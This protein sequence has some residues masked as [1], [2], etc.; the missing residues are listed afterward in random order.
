MLLKFSLIL[1]LLYSCNNSEKKKIIFP[2]KAPSVGTENLQKSANGL[3]IFSPAEGSLVSLP[4]ELKGKVKGT[5]FFEA[6]FGVKLLDQNYNVLAESYVS[7]TEDWMTEDWVPFKGRLG[8]PCPG[9]KYWFFN[10]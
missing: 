5:W 1:I 10:F 6:V 9:I 8:I 3:Q 7:A 4:V 2:E